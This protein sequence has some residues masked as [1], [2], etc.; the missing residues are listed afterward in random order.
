MKWWEY[1]PD[2]LK[3][4]D[5]T[6]LER[7]INEVENRIRGGFSEYRSEKIQLDTKNNKISIITEDGLESLVLD[8]L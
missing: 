1:D 5:I 7:I 2:V 8:N 4:L 3:G 6:E